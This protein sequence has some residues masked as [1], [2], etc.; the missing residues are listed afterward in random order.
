MSRLIQITV[1]AVPVGSVYALAASGLVLT[2]R[3][4]RVFNFAHGAVGMFCAFLFYQAWQVW[5]LPL[6]LAFIVVVVGFAPAMALLLERLV[7][8]QLRDAATSVKVVVT[9]G[10]LIALQGGASAIWGGTALFLPPV[11]PQGSIGLVGGVRM[12]F[13]Q[14]SIVAVSLGTMLLLGAL[15]RFT[16]FGL[17]VRASVDRPDLAELVGVDTARVS[18]VSWT[19]GF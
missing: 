11:F 15:I 19:V 7:F 18:A 10:L 4:S 1:A 12:G 17:H 8:R 14:L 2:Y 5:K 6:P 16:R 13:D 3:T 9:V